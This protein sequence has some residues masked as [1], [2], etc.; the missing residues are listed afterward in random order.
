MLPHL[1]D[2]V[3]RTMP[4]LLG[5]CLLTLC[6]RDWWRGVGLAYV[7]RER[8]MVLQHAMLGMVLLAATVALLVAIHSALFPQ[9]DHC[10]PSPGSSHLPTQIPLPTLE[11]RIDAQRRRDFSA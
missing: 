10:Q 3:T 5:S 4:Q 2:G 9:V 11:P 7:W 8:F 6:I 1:L